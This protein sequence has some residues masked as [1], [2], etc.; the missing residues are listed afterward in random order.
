MR[1]VCLARIL[2]LQKPQEERLVR[3][4]GSLDFSAEAGSGRLEAI[5]GWAI[6]YQLHCAVWQAG[7]KQ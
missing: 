4:V 3:S 2:H 5:D 6:H 1:I 7:K